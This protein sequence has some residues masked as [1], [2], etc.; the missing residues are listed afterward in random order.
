VLAAGCDAVMS[1]PVTLKD[2]A[3]HRNELPMA[4]QLV[5][6]KDDEAARIYS[7]VYALPDNSQV[8]HSEARRFDSREDAFDYTMAEYARLTAMGYEEERAKDM[9]DLNYSV[10]LLTEDQ[11]QNEYVM[12]FVED[13]I[14]AMLSV[15]GPRVIFGEMYA[16]SRYMLYHIDDDFATPSIDDFYS[17]DREQFE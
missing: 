15:K 3:I 2:V 6:E 14:A 4:Y 8:I 16:L 7:I 1:D 13:D 10:S 12:L 17:K 5:E 11:Q 9:G